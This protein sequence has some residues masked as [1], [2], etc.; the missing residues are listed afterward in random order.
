MDK[1]KELLKLT[2]QAVKVAEQDSSVEVCQLEA[3]DIN[4]IMLINGHDVNAFSQSVFDKAA[5]MR[6]QGADKVEI[7]YSTSYCSNP[8]GFILMHSAL[9][10]GRKYANPT[11]EQTKNS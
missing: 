6:R 9:L 3:T 1:M 5:E 2:K 10:I 7:Q 11:V 8:A 4:A